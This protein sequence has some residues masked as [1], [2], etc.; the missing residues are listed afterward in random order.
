MAMALSDVT[1]L[2]EKELGASR[3]VR[4]AENLE[5]YSVDESGLGPYLPD[6]A[7]VCHEA[8][9]VALVLKLASEHRIPVTPRGAGSGMTGGAL[10]IRGG[11]VLSTEGMQK[12]KEVDEESLLAVVEPGVITGEF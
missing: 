3:V 11:I 7:V 2:L 10:P 8:A 6:C 12:I 1:T 9:E 5:K 4:N